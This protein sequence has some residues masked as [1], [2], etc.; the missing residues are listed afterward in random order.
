[1]LLGNYAVDAP[2][3]GWIDFFIIKTLQNCVSLRGIYTNW[4]A[5]WNCI[6]P[7]NRE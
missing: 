4:K 2:V 3:H 5:Q 7:Q 1:M 6:L